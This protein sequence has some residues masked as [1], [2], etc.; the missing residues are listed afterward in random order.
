MVTNHGTEYQ[1]GSWSP[2]L[3]YGITV[4]YERFR[5]IWQFEALTDHFPPGVFS[6]I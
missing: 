3:K 2:Q 4:C 1:T 5:A 6:D